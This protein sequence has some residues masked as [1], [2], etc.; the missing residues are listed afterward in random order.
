MLPLQCSSVNESFG[1]TDVVTTRNE[2]SS[3]KKSALHLSATSSIPSSTGASSPSSC[4][5]GLVGAVLPSVVAGTLRSG[6]RSALSYRG[7]ATSEDQEKVQDAN[8]YPPQSTKALSSRSNHVSFSS[9]S[10]TTELPRHSD[11]L[12]DFLRV[13]AKGPAAELFY[14]E[15]KDQQISPFSTFLS[16]P[17]SFTRDNH[18]MQT[19]PSLGQPGTHETTSALT[20]HPDFPS[21]IA[22]PLDPPVALPTVEVCRKLSDHFGSPQSL[23][24]TEVLLEEDPNV[25]PPQSSVLDGAARA[26]ADGTSAQRTENAWAAYSGLTDVE[27]PVSTSDVIKT[28][29]LRNAS[30]RASLDTLHN[31]QEYEQSVFQDV[32]FVRAPSGNHLSNTKLFSCGTPLHLTTATHIVMFHSEINVSLE[33]PRESEERGRLL[34]FSESTPHATMAT[35]SPRC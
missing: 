35:V 27:F 2:F 22:L 29:L 13:A 30:S 12:Q 34:D 4:V 11:A 28:T 10:A 20:I 23:S 15:P 25:S 16:E 18:E 24:P 5:A 14:D 8:F 7:S 26:E 31:A 6:F 33:T 17:H 9:L 1:E 21:S 3:R 32:A 19:E